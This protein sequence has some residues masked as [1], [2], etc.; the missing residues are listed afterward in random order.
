MKKHQLNTKLLPIRLL[1]DETLRNVAN[2]IEN[3]NDKTI[4]LV[5]NMI[6]TLKKTDG[7]GLAAPQV[8]ESLRIFIVNPIWKKSGKMIVFIN[9]ELMQMEDEQYGE[10]GCLSIPQV[11]EKVRRAKRVFIKAMNLKEKTKEYEFTETM[12]R[13][14][15]HETDHLDG[16]LFIDKLPKFKRMLLGKKLKQI[17]STTKQGINIG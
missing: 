9:P 14:V 6:Y 1:G 12:A 5:K 10:E 4:D 13:V 3:L 8:G 11:F 16:I 2:P 7:I 15:Q 17:A